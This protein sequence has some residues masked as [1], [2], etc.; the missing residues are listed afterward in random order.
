MTE[1]RRGPSLPC[2]HLAH[3]ARRPAFLPVQ[4][5]R[6]LCILKEAANERWSLFSKVRPDSLLLLSFLLSLSLKRKTK[7][8][9]NNTGMMRSLSLNPTGWWCSVL[10][11]RPSA[12]AFHYCQRLELRRSKNNKKKVKDKNKEK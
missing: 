8:P 3:L 9:L 6:P 10:E 11:G 12:R 5:R 2:L 4:L 7:H 1:K